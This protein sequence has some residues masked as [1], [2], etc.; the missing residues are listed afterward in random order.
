MPGVLMKRIGNVSCLVLILFA[1]C[2]SWKQAAAAVRENP[3]RQPSAEIRALWVDGFHAGIRSREE[4][5]QL[6]TDAKRANINTLF[7]QVRRRGDALYSKSIEPPVE[8]P[9]YDGKYDGLAAIIE[10]AHREGIQVHAWINAMPIWRELPAPND[11][12]HVF[13]QHGLSKSG[14]NNWLTSNPQGEMKFPVGYFLDPGHPAAA[15]YLV[16]VYLNIVRNYDVDGIH[17]DYIRY[18]ETEERPTPTR[19]A[20]VGYNE[21][22]LARFQ[23]A[24]KRTDKPALDDPQ[25]T[26]WRRRQVT[27]LVRRIYIESKAIKAR[28]KVSAALIP[29]GK[30][31]KGEKDF[32]DASP[33]QRI[34]QDWHSWLKE[35][36][37][38]LAVPMNY[39]RENDNAVRNWFDGWIRWEK[40]HKHGRQLA[41]G[42]GTYLNPKEANL[43][44][45]ARVRK[46]E[47]MQRVD[48]MS[49][50]SYSSFF[51]AAGSRVSTQARA[52]AANSDGLD[53]FTRGLPKA[54]A[55]FSQPAQV[56]GMSWI[57]NPT[58][59]WV[60]GLARN[61]SG[62]MLDGAA[63][64]LRKAGGG[65]FRGVRRELSDGNGYFGFAGVPPGR[66]EVRFSG[67]KHAAEKA[68]V[69]VSA[70]KV[71]RVEL[72][73]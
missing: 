57:E 18:P 9:A 34:F 69:V 63:V 29:W 7:V 36:I 54:P 10:A 23:R 59:G 2:S 64:E 6:V 25:W 32:L 15:A 3:T 51:A 52:S 24:M 46:P 4:V 71:A 55:P 61:A 44:Q 42:L 12:R 13:N 73:K 45:I 66:Y 53:Y 50:F 31:P 14:E 26:N 20:P 49:F 47:G 33:G 16:E 39:A 27:Q 72:K 37:L 21:T 22:S 58:T 40:K 56:P 11:P 1:L 38:D 43:A 5:A 67:A 19:G 35:G 48:G 65:L 8:D 17:F 62:K 30:P 60:A 68:L 70:G 28:V 41:V